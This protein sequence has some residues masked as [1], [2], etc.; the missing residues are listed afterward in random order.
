LG[1]KK[2]TKEDARPLVFSIFC[3]AIILGPVI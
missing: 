3:G 1:L 2:L